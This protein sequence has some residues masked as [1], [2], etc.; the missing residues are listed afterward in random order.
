MK[1]LQKQL[2]FWPTFMSCTKDKWWIL[3]YFIKNVAKK[4]KILIFFTNLKYS[5]FSTGPPRFVN[6]EDRPKSLILA[7]EETGSISC[8]ADA[9]PP[10]SWKWKCGGIE[11]NKAHPNWNK[12]SIDNSDENK[13]T[14]K[15][16]KI[17]TSRVKKIVVPRRFLAFFANSTIVYQTFTCLYVIYV[18]HLVFYGIIRQSLDGNFTCF[19]H[20]AFFS[21]LCVQ[22]WQCLTT[23]CVFD[24][25][26]KT[27]LHNFFNESC[28]QFFNINQSIHCWKHT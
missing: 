12:F 5:L 10:A 19:E 16:R 28:P 6:Y 20:N 17:E 1:F 3:H 23:F 11:V 25:N 26:C 14:L 4:T 9:Q 22:L 2:K 27:F 24:G 21:S 13:S 8:E 7:Y 15:V 18:F